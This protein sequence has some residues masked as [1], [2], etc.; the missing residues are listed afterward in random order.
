MT[1]HL[2]LTMFP[3][4]VLGRVI[5]PVPAIGYGDSSVHVTPDEIDRRIMMLLSSEPEL[6]LRDVARRLGRSPSAITARV[7]RLRANITPEAGIS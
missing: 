4:K 7:A 2:S 6:S 3:L 1:V 5:G